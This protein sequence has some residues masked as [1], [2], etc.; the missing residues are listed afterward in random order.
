MIEIILGLFLLA[1]FTEAITELVVKSE[2]FRPF[3]KFLFDKNLKFLHSLVDCGYC[4]SVWAAFFVVV[5]VLCLDNILV[6]LLVLG[7][8]VHRLSNI[9]HFLI[10]HLSNH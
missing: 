4:F 5:S 2:I 6:Y 7:V 3:R 1:L 9:I 8:V 10:D